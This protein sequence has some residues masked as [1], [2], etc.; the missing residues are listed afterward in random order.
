LKDKNFESNARE[1]L[2]FEVPEESKDLTGL[3]V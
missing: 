2:D 1:G 3:Y